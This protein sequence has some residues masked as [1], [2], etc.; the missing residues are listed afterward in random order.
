[1]S[2]PM[3]VCPDCGGDG[4]D[5]CHNPDHGFIN[6]LTFHDIGR[7]GCPVCGHDPKHKTSSKAPCET[8]EG[9]GQVSLESAERFCSDLNYDFEHVMS[10]LDKKFYPKLQLIDEQSI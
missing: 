6:M 2:D 3:F 7:L 8:C 4:K 10:M 5:T 1:M 9:I